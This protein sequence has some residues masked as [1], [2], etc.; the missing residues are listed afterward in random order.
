MPNETTL[1]DN[2]TVA[3]G[4]PSI[5]PPISARALSVVGQV[6]DRQGNP[7]PGI[8]VT[9]HDFCAGIYELIPFGGSCYTGG[10]GSFS[11]VTGSSLFNKN[12]L[13]FYDATG[14][15]HSGYYADADGVKKVVDNFLDGAIIDFFLSVANDIGVIPLQWGA[16]DLSP[17]QLSFGDVALPSSTTQMVTASN[18]STR[19]LTITGIAFQA[20]SSLDFAINSAT[21]PPISL[22]PGSYVEIPITYTPHTIG[23]ATATLVVTVTAPDDTQEHQLT[24]TLTGAGV[25]SQAPPAEQVNDTVNFIQGAVDQGTLTGTGPPAANNAQVTALLNQIKAAGDMAAKGNSKAACQQLL[26]ALQRTDGD[27]Q[28]P[29]LV[30][31]PAAAEL[32]L[33]IQLTRQQLGCN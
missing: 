3:W 21:S 33:L 2:W 10:D 7:V 19:D 32:M 18:V 31:G 12:R 13:R 16:L 25:A 23:A 28:P 24:A 9:M 15:Y 30:E 14:T 4:K 27:P 26:N 29:D 22:T 6:V 20:G 11:F 8:K 17:P 1:V 5:D